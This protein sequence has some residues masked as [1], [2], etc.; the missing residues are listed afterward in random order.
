MKNSMIKVMGI[1]TMLV[2]IVLP[3]NVFAKEFGM[4]MVCTDNG[5]YV[6]YVEGIE[7]KFDYA[8]SNGA[9]KN[10]SELDYINSI[11]DEEGNHVAFVS[12]EKYE[13]I[14]AGENYLYIK[15]DEG[16][17]IRGQKIDF[18][19]ALNQ[20]AFNF[21]EN[22]TKRINTKIV[23][24]VKQNDDE[25]GLKIEVNVGGIKITEKG[26]QKYSYAITKL[27]NGLYSE[28]V[29]KVNEINEKYDSLDMYNRIAS[30]KDFYDLYNTLVGQQQWKDVED[31]TIEQP[32]DAEN[33][34]QYVVFIKAVDKNGNE[35]T[36]VKLMESYRRDEIEKI[37]ASTENKVVQ[38]TSKLPITYDSMFLIIAL[39]TVVAIAVVVYVRIKKLQKEAK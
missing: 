8:I 15:N 32:E 14:K 21:V 11:S 18:A 35:T 20:D 30:A 13:T 33:G 17:I 6:I 16:S 9:E 26:N 39:S 23:N 29:Q 7:S 1:I 5:D 34:E 27:P 22:T 3:A 38:E 31:A 25:G 24:V 12:K 2:M 28:L 19:S 36:D 10:D 4:Q 37:P